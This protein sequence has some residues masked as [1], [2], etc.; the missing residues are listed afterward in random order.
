MFLDQFF[1]PVLMM[2]PENTKFACKSAKSADFAQ[3][4][5]NRTNVIVR[6]IW[7]KFEIQVQFFEPDLITSTIFA[8]TGK[9]V[10]N[11]QNGTES[12]KY[13]TLTDSDEI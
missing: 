1:E 5:Q 10:Q 13:E 12:A 4:L 11:L 7:T 9:F 3:N 6:L 8:E 2:S